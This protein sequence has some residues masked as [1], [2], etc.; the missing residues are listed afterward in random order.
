MWSKN[1]KYNEDMKKLVP[2]NEKLKGKVEE[3]KRRNEDLKSKAVIKPCIFKSEKNH[4]EK[5][6]TGIG[7]GIFEQSVRRNRSNSVP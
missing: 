3:L 7:N 6:E 2:K 1:R 4:T 5:N